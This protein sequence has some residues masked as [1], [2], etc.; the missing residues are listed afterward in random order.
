MV[1][2]GIPWA[3]SAVALAEA[4]VRHDHRAAIAVSV[5]LATTTVLTAITWVPTHGVDGAVAA[6]LAG[7]T[8]SAL[9]AGVLHVRRRSDA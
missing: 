5:V 3:I 2:G 8:A 7:T 1:L 6:W 4:R 9:V